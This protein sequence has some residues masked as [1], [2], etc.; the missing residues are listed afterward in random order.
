V[1]D[2]EEEFRAAR[3]AGGDDGIVALHTLA[4]LRTGKNRKPALATLE[5]V[6]GSAPAGLPGLALGEAHLA[7]GELEAARR[8]FA[9]V[10][11]AGPWTARAS[12]RLAELDL[13]AFDRSRD[14]HRLADADAEVHRALEQAPEYLP[15]RAVIGRLLVLTG[16]PE[17]ALAAFGPVVAANRDTAADDLAL[18]DAYITGG[19]RDRAKDAL[20]R[21]VKKGAALATARALAAKIDRRFAD[22]LGK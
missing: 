7:A 22:E 12:V 20:R 13:A 21:A 19:D 11:P 3:S 8:A 16:Q 5:L 14:A 6:A 17:G 9:A 15:A 2:A 18:A 10:S 1:E 4:Q